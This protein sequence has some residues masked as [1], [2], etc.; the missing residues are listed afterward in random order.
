[1]DVVFSNG[2]PC[3]F[4]K[5]SQFNSPHRWNYDRPRVNLTTSVAAALSRSTNFGVLIVALDQRENFAVTPCCI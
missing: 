2:E 5:R 1:V 3:T 4:A